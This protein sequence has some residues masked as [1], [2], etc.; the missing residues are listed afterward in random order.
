MAMATFRSVFPVDWDE[1]R[2]V[3]SSDA[4]WLNVVCG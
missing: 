1:L 4:V 2:G 3:A